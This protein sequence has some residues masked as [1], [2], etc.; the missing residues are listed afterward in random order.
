MYY[1]ISSLNHFKKLN[2]DW[3]L[4]LFSCFELRTALSPQEI[5]IEILNKNMMPTLIDYW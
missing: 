3:R 1:T 5:K 4:A 2:C